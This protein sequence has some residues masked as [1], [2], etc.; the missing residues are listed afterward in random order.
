MKNN[1]TWQ[2]NNSKLSP[3][4]GSQIKWLNFFECSLSIHRFRHISTLATYNCSRIS[5]ICLTLWY[6][7]L[8]LTISNTDFQVMSTRK[9]ELQASNAPKMPHEIAGKRQMSDQKQKTNTHME[10]GGS[11]TWTERLERSKRLPFNIRGTSCV[12]S[13]TLPLRVLAKARRNLYHL[14]R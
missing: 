4:N 7:V 8:Y 10:K 6:D 3:N 11:S 2:K 12:I 1:Q 14:K 5:K 9:N 13:E